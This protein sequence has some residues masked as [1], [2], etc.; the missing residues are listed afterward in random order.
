MI[1]LFHGP[2]DPRSFEPSAP[3]IEPPGGI[4]AGIL[5][6]EIHFQNIQRSGFGCRP[7]P[8]LRVVTFRL[9]QRGGALFREKTCQKSPGIQFHKIELPV[10]LQR[11][12]RNHARPV[13]FRSKPGGVRSRRTEEIDRITTEKHLKRMM[14]ALPERHFKK[15]SIE[16]TDNNLSSGEFLCLLRNFTNGICR[17]DTQITAKG[18]F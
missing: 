8:Q 4:A 16:G 18:L 10:F 7:L 2:H 5:S 13:K 12:N 17:S 3:H 15:I 14:I 6:G 11:C 1:K 9:N